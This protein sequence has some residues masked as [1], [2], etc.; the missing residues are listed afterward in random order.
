MGD[1]QAH[2]PILSTTPR[3][4][5]ELAQGIRQRGHQPHLQLSGEEVRTYLNISFLY[6]TCY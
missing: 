3:T 6:L 1:T 2:V 4:P 5:P